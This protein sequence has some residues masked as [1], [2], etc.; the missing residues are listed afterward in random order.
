MVK[1]YS[2]D[3]R[4]R[5]VE[6]VADGFS[7]HEAAALFSVSVANAVRWCQ[8]ENQTGSAAARPMGG[9]R[10]KLLEGQRD[11]LMARIAAKPDLTLEALLREVHAR[12][13]HV[14]LDTLWRFLKCCGH[15]FKKNRSRQRTG[16]ARHC[17]KA[18]LVEEISNAD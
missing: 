8:L 4:V 6:A 18:L 2:L 13:S 15:S 3:L 14:S 17:Q 10:P 5:V 16:P 12:G 1:P 7:R 9:K 11:F